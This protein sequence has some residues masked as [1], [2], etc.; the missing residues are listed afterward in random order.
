MSA[1]CANNLPVSLVV[2]VIHLFRDYLVSHQFLAV[3]GV[4]LTLDPHEFREDPL[5]PVLPLV[6]AVTMATVHNILL[7]YAG[8]TTEATEDCELVKTSY[9]YMP[10]VYAH[11]PDFIHI[12]A[13]I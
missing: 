11:V 3:L 2:L 5:A 10:G 8:M 7:Y 6:P 1:Q 13:T 12:F 9:M 4:H